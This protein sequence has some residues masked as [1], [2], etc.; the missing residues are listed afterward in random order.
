MMEALSS[1]GVMVLSSEDWD[2]LGYVYGILMDIVLLH[3]ASISAN[4]Y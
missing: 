3:F 4:L 1:G 2:I